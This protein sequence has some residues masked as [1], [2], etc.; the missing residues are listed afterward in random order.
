MEIL[1]SNA[2]LGML[3]HPLSPSH[4]HISTRQTRM[5]MGFKARSGLHPC[6]PGMSG[7]VTVRECLTCKAKTIL[8]QHQ[9]HLARV[10]SVQLRL[11]QQSKKTGTL[12][13]KRFSQ[14][15]QPH[16]EVQLMMGTYKYL[17]IYLKACM[18][19]S[20]PTFGGSKDD[21]LLSPNACSSSR[22]MVYSR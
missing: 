18:L 19:V 7:T 8:R 13:A 15:V 12:T 21:I 5:T 20:G 22:M 16:S 1:L 10:E 11:P 6:L 2:D 14:A 4:L 3:Q 17:L 9:A